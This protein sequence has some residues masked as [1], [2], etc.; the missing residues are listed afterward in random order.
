MGDGSRGH[1]LVEGGRGVTVLAQRRRRRRKELSLQRLPR[2]LNLRR[3]MVAFIL[4]KWYC[5]ETEECVVT[6][7]V[8][9][10]AS[11]MTH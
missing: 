7:H 4:T 2:M 9:T 5:R 6:E 10:F 11:T 8:R 1:A 3:K